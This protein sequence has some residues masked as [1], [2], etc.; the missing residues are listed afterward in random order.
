MPAVLLERK[1]ELGVIEYALSRAAHGSG[2]TVLVEG[3]A[4]IGKTALLAEACALAQAQELTVLKAVGLCFS[5]AIIWDKM[6]PILTRKDRMGRRVE[7]V[8]FAW[9]GGRW[10]AGNDIRNRTATL[11][12]Y[13]I[14][15][16]LPLRFRHILSSVLVSC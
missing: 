13:Q 2:G 7:R 6:D 14:P 11:R 1:T 3:P 4:G 12:M 16:D 5:Q 10:S 9:D 8:A 15:P